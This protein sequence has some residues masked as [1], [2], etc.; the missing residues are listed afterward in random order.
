MPPELPDRLRARSL[1]SLRM[2]S[3][4]RGSTCT[5]SSASRSSAP[6]SSRVPG[7]SASA[8]STSCESRARRLQKP[9]AN[10]VRSQMAIA[11]EWNPGM[12]TMYVVVLAAK[13]DAW[14]GRARSQLELGPNADIDRFDTGTSALMSSPAPGPVAFTSVSASIAGL[15]DPPM[16]GGTPYAVG[17][18]SLVRIPIPGTN[19]RAIELK[20]RWKPKTGLTSTLFFQD[21]TG[22]RHLRLDNGHNVTTNTIDYRTRKRPQTCSRSRTIHQPAALSRSPMKAISTFDTLVACSR[23]R[24]SPLT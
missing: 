12:D 17:Q 8:T 5:S 16:S 11:V 15:V 14:E 23:W 3:S 9:M 19:G 18:A 20:G 2:S 21:I 10:L 22:K 1:A 13:V 7:G 6:A 4:R 24:A